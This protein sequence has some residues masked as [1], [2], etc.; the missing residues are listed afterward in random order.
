MKLFSDVNIITKILSGFGLVAITAGAYASRAEFNRD[1]AAE[2]AGDD[3]G[4][5]SMFKIIGPLNVTVPSKQHTADILPQPAAEPQ[6]RSAPTAQKISSPYHTVSTP[7]RP[8]Q[9]AMTEFAAA[10][11]NPPVKKSILFFDDTVEYGG[12]RS[13]NFG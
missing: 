7:Q 12:T 9:D 5:A 11:Q 3:E 8:A 6:Y 10:V 4:S 2:T 1:D 13:V